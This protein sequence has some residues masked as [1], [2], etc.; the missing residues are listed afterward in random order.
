MAEAEVEIVRRPRF[1]SVGE[2]SA[3]YQAFVK[4][5]KQAR[6]NSLDRRAAVGCTDGP[7]KH[8]QETLLTHFLFSGAA[9]ISVKS[10]SGQHE[11]NAIL[12][13][14]TPIKLQD[15][16]RL[17]PFLIDETDG[18]L[19]T[20]CVNTCYIVSDGALKSPNGTIFSNTE[21]MGCINGLALVTTAV[22][23]MSSELKGLKAVGTT[24]IWG[25]KADSFRHAVAESQLSMVANRVSFLRSTDLL[26]A[27]PANLLS[28]FAEAMD[29]V[30]F[31]PGVELMVQGDKGDHLFV[32]TSGQVEVWRHN[33]PAGPDGSTMPPPP[34]GTSADRGKKLTTLGRGACLGEMALLVP[35]GLRSAT[36]KVPDD[37]KE[38]AVCLVLGRASFAA[39]LQSSATDAEQEAAVVAMARDDAATA[40]M[41]VSAL[42]REAQLRAL[43]QVPL[44]SSLGRSSLEAL[45][46][47]SDLTP[48]TDKAAVDSGGGGG[49][50]LHTFGCGE[51]IA[52]AGVVAQSMFVIH[53][54]FVKQDRGE[55][56]ESELLGPGDYFGVDSLFTGEPLDISYIAADPSGGAIAPGREDHID[57]LTAAVESTLLTDDERAGA[58]MANHNMTEVIVLSRDMFERLLGEA[59]VGALLEDHVHCQQR[60][61]VLRAVPLLSKLTGLRDVELDIVASLLRYQLFRNGETIVKKGETGKALYVVF[62]GDAEIILNNDG[63]TTML[64]PKSHVGAEGLIGNPYENTIRAVAAEGDTVTCL[65]L[66][67]KNLDAIGDASLSQRLRE[68]ATGRQQR[69][70]RSDMMRR[71]SSE[72]QNQ[73]RPRRLSVGQGMQS[74]LPENLQLKDLEILRVLGEGNYGRVKLVLH[75]E[76][77]FV[78]ALKTMN[79]HRIVAK[80]QVSNVNREACILH[81]VA[82]PFVLRCVSTF[83]TKCQIFMLLELVQS[84][85]LWPYIYRKKI[86]KFR[87]ALPR[88]PFGGFETAH[89]LFYTANLVSALEYIH[90]LGIAYRD[91][92]PENLVF[93]GTGYLKV[94]DFG[95]SKYIPQLNKSASSAEATPGSRNSGNA[96]KA[97]RTS[98]FSGMMGGTKSA[99]NAHEK[100]FTM[101]G[102]TEYLCPEAVTGRGHDKSIDLWA[103]GCLVYELFVG[104]T[105]FRGKQNEATLSNIVNSKSHLSDN[106]F[107]MAG[108]KDATSLIKGLLD[109]NP[110]TRLGNTAKGW[111]AITGHKFFN[112]V[113]F[114]KLL[115]RQ[116]PAPFTPQVE[117]ALDMSGFEDS[118]VD[119]SK[120]EVIP[121]YS[122][123]QSG[124]ADFGGEFARESSFST[125]PSHPSAMVASLI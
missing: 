125:I 123:D 38:S 79:K 68:A 50:F 58:L 71:L 42:R 51:M 92:K 111:S 70:S 73:R 20:E 97:K 15:G 66:D 12:A 82:H 65:V 28:R 78:L 19:N 47:P 36:V 48:S 45:L 88:T 3:D 37:A 121:D 96:I 2:D 87:D 102:T 41:V 8:V 83:Q 94:I 69:K 119:M 11:L 7:P 18:T 113:D 104:R 85:D 59:A 46:G 67:K 76:T 75:E 31:S 17:F 89:A 115:H 80:K 122:G 103:L 106:R 101:C 55:G 33:L 72:E 62:E 63:T 60:R 99:G 21:N 30:V 112:G 32:V 124:F 34:P 43:E 16:D 39:L 25:L 23:E 81:R 107:L 4:H 57:T 24:L 53:S 98:I 90:S 27:A 6:R 105:P 29:E 22:E 108:P 118:D 74:E 9:G 13:V 14:M 100:S 35:N 1:N 117:S 95:L 40:T 84:G 109:A 120:P 110:A 114:E 91:L 56:I 116:L 77:G 54:G 5:N 64:P 10:S 49:G 26:G 52:Q 44:L 61:A 93:E 86:P